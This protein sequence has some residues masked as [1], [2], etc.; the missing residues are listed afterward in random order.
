MRVSI[1]TLAYAVS[2]S[3]TLDQLGLDP[4]IKVLK[5]IFKSAFLN[6]KIKIKKPLWKWR[7][8]V[9]SNNNKTQVRQKTYRQNIGAIQINI[10]QMKLD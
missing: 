1:L 7:K 2:P 6:S 3:N 10:K 5:F 9:L 8:E 4:G